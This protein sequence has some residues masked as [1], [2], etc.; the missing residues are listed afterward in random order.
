M[1]CVMKVLDPKHG[2]FKVRWDPDNPEE[3][4]NARKQFDELVKS[5]ARRA[6]QAYKIA[7]GARRK[8]EP[9]K[10]FDPTAGE[11]LLV[12]QMAGGR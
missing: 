12:P 9:I 3:V 4:E 10:E 2:D 1:T 7:S 5:T 11:L 8:G 6:Y